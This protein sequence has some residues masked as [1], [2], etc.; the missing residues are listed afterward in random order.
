[1]LFSLISAAQ[2][3]HLI[4]STFR[5]ASSQL[6]A[7]LCQPHSVHSPP[8]SPHPAYVYSSQSLSTHSPSIFSS[9]FHFRPETHLFH[10]SCPPQSASFLRTA[11]HATGL[12]PDLLFSFLFILLFVNQTKLYSR[13]LFVA[14]VDPSTNTRHK[15]LTCDFEFVGKRS[16]TKSYIV[17][18]DDRAQQ[19]VKRDQSF[20]YKHEFHPL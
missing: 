8:D 17:L 13:Q 1:M 7:S 15:T 10:K 14:R 16:L 11:F 12:G 9:V 5:Y 3:I 18:L 20:V 19:R 2:T 4:Y 6:P